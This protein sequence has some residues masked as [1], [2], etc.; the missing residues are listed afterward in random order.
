MVVEYKLLVYKLAA[1]LIESVLIDL[2]HS[3]EL[4][5]ILLLE[6][7]SLFRKLISVR[8][9]LNASEL[10]KKGLVLYPR[11]KLE[12]LICIVLEPVV[13]VVIAYTGTSREGNSL[14]VIGR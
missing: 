3:V 13:Y 11:K 2:G 7:V 1:L 14:S 5:V 12:I 6:V 4:S 8:Q 9:C 10:C